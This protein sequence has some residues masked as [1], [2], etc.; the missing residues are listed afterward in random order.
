MGR[1]FDF[2]PDKGAYSGNYQSYVSQDGG[3][4]ESVCRFF[5]TQ[6][7]VYPCFP[8]LSAL[9]NSFNA[10][11][12][13]I[14]LIIPVSQPYCNTS[15][16]YSYI[17]ACVFMLRSVLILIKTLLSLSMTVYV[18]DTLQNRGNT[19]KGET[20]ASEKNF[21]MKLQFACAEK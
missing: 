11:C 21:T 20:D 7:V 5:I 1:S 4:R 15:H 8:P 18:A 3:K 2:S 13:V 6:F 17:T 16:V 19:S 14:A 9:D 10:V 12:G